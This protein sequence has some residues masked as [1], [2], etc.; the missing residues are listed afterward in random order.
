MQNKPTSDHFRNYVKLNALPESPLVSVVMPSF[1]QGLYIKSSI[2]S[3]LRQSYRPLE[4]IIVDG[5]ST[6]ET[7]DILHG[8]DGEN[9]VRWTSEP[10]SGVVE[11]VNKGL[12]LATGQIMAIQSSDDL[13]FDDEVVTR[14]VSNLIEH[15][16][17]LVYGNTVKIDASG[18]VLRATNYES[19][20]LEAFLLKT[21]HIPQEACFFRKELIEE[22]G[23]WREEF[24][25]AADTDFFL[26]MALVSKAVH[27]SA[28]FGRRMMHSGQRFEQKEKIAR[29][30]CKMIDHNLKHFGIADRYKKLAEI[31]KLLTD[32][33]YR[34][35]ERVLKRFA[36]AW[37]VQRLSKVLEI[38]SPLSPWH[39]L[40]I[41]WFIMRA[42]NLFRLSKEKV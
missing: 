36:M 34:P 28:N 19:F 29:D 24:S 23:G 7:I 39:S 22:V 9:G 30:Y 2:E 10:D 11:A 14:A 42:L 13:Y 20:S 6:D 16:A 15:G 5:N 33:K 8:Y 41:Y 4:L 26:R 12:K 3:I 37:E 38:K 25:Y 31:S 18:V 21:T 1:N 27:V 40:G 17:G 35:Q 32:I